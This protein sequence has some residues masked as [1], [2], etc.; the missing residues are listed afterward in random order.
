LEQICF[1]L[2]DLE[3]E[4]GEEDDDRDSSNIFLMP[5]RP[6]I[7]FV[8]LHQFYSAQALNQASLLNK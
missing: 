6:L 2:V 5:S 8:L 4:E 1:L 7:W 3:L